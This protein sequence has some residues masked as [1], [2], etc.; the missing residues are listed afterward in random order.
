MPPV[1]CKDGKKP[2]FRV[3]KTK[4]GNVRLAFCGKGKVIEAKKIKKK[5]KKKKKM[6]Y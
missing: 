1:K 5:K 6:G 2:R 4:K 3:K